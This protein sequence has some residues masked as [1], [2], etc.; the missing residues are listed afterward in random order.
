MIQGMA[1]QVL[2]QL[3]EQLNCSICLDT[4]TNPKLLQCFHVYCQQC[5]VPL[6]EQ[7][8]RGRLGLTCPNCRQV[9]RVPDRGVVGLQSAFHMNRFLEIK[10]SFQN[11]ENPA[12][13]PQGAIP[14]DV[15]V[16]V[17]VNHCSVHE[18]KELELYCETCGELICNKCA[19]KGGKHRDH[20]YEELEQAFKKYKAQISSLQKPTEK[21]LET[22]KKALVKLDTRCEE[23]TNQR[24]G[25]ENKIHDTFRRLREI[26][27][28]RETEL[29]CQL[30][31]MTQ[32]KL[33]YL[34]SQRDQIETALAQ[35]NSC[36]YFMRE[37]LK[38][39]SKKGD[40]LVVNNV[41]MMKADML[42]RVKELSTQLDLEHNTHSNVVFSVSAEM[43]AAYQNYGQVLQA[44]YF[45][46]PLSINVCTEV[47]V[48]KEVTAILQAT[49]IH[50]KPY[51]D[52][53]SLKC[54][55]LSEIT[56]ARTYC[57]V[58]RRGRSQYEINYQPTV[59]GRHQLRIKGDNQHIKGSPF[60]I[61]AKSPV[62][63]LGVPILTVHGVDGPWGVAIHQNGEMV[64]TEWCGNRISVFSPS[65]EKLRSFGKRGFEFGL[66]ELDCP[67]EVAVDTKGD[68]LVVN[69]GKHCITKFTRE[70]QFV[71]TVGTFGSGPQSFCFPTGIALNASNNK[72]YVT[73][74]DNDRV[75]VL[76]SDLTFSG[77]F[78][79]KGSSPGYFSFPTG[80]ACDSTGKVYVAD[81]HGVQVF[82]AEGKS[83]LIWFGR[84]K[85]GRGELELYRPCAVA[86]DTN[87]MVYVGEEHCVS[88]FNSEGHFVT[89]FGRGGGWPGAFWFPRGLAVDSSGVVYVCDQNNKRVQI[90]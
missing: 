72:W 56:G 44:N 63:S 71:T 36:L 3:E 83:F 6:V 68:I 69:S 9:T 51:K 59:K 28:V 58:E 38:V 81:K 82:T 78:G 20:D 35:L 46:D 29:I 27:D 22:M 11:P 32:D 57:R 8:Q 33:K 88:V 14:T 23:I 85:H 47:P 12:A 45:Q 90:F 54:E 37:S 39:D 42:K 31:Q 49:N 55:L 10:E 15:D 2:K 18:G 48:G 53:A 65:G 43:T 24:A 50:G 1:E 7:D 64:V 76:N 34:A 19:L 70:G 84:G 75:Q 25:T 60:G 13:T 40:I 80:I 30:D 62:E 41:L 26:L 66:E 17:K 74:T 87:D 5:L 61:A 52:S 67:S 16:A 79:K 21:Q 4:Y 77:T 89:S 73:D 86:I